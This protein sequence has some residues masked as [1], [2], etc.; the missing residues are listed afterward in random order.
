MDMSVQAKGG[1][2]HRVFSCDGFTSVSR[3]FV[4]EWAAIV[5]DLVAG[6]LIAGAMAAWVPDDFWRTFFPGGPSA[7][8][9]AEPSSHPRPG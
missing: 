2:A 9:Q 3:I 6:L 1:L 8:R 5:R 7:R 4:M